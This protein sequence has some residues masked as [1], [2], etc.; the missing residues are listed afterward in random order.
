MAAQVL[1]ESVARTVSGATPS[2][3]GFGDAKTLR[4]QL[5][6]TAVAGVAPALDVVLED[7]LDGTNWN[8]LGAFAQRTTVGREVINITTPFSDRLRLRW[9]IGG[10]TP[11]A[12]FSVVVYSE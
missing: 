6:V 4:V 1:V 9:T 5:H 12:T 2:T 11:S 8:V 7:T 3:A 10:T